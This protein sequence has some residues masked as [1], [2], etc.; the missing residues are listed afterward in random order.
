MALAGIGSPVYPAQKAS[1]KSKAMEKILVFTA[2]YNEA[3]NIEDLITEVFRYLPTADVL[4]VDD[5]SPDGTGEILNRISGENQ[6]VKVIHRREKLGLG[7]AHICGMEYAIEHQYDALITM[8][9]DFSHLPEYLP[10][11]LEHLKTRDFVIGSR[12][13]EGGGLDYGVFR[14][15][16]SKTANLLARFLLGIRLRECTTSYRGFSR[17]LLLEFPRESIRSDGYSFFVEAVYHI[18]R[19]TSNVAEFPIRFELRRAGKSKI[20]EKEILKAALTL[21]RLFMRRFL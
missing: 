4:V 13:A 16:L 19:I 7:T 14:T 15:L 17:K 1:G 9:A 10:T 3:G 8:D 2:T 21:F 18:C 5:N 11:L 6:R 12:Y 20:S